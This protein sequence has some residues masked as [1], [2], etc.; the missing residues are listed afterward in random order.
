MAAIGGVIFTGVATYYSALVAD[1]QLQQSRQD[2]EREE[3]EQAEV[4]SY[5][6]SPSFSTE[7][8]RLHVVNRSPD[9]VYSLQVLL[10]LE[11]RHPSGNTAV[12]AGFN[13]ET[14]DVAPCT[15]KIYNFSDLQFSPFPEVSGHTLT[16]VRVLWL[17][18]TDRAGRKWVRGPGS[19]EPRQG[20]LDYYA[21]RLKHRA[22]TTRPPEVK[23]VEACGLSG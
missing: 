15:E 6:L 21:R 7:G 16:D 3:Q 2:G 17:T 8:Q 18:F 5:W 9:P 13:T 12:K 19:L 20:A 22:A 11:M 10:L 14:A 1:D 4:V 23:V